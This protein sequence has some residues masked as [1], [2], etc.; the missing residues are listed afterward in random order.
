MRAD[1]HRA[2][3][4]LSD[5]ANYCGSLGESSYARH[6]TVSIRGPD[7]DCCQCW[8]HDTF[9]NHLLDEVAHEPPPNKRHAHVNS[10]LHT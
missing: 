8:S 7:D 4:L 10:D 6:S 3:Q 5:V 1:S 2:M 9:R